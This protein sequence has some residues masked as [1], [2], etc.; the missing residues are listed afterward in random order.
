MKY[1]VAN[2]KLNGNTQFFK[3]YFRELKKYV[4]K[5]SQM[6]FAVPNCYLHLSKVLPNFAIG[7]QNI[8]HK[9]SGACTGEISAE[10]A[11]DLGAQFCLVGHSECRKRGETDNQIEQKLKLSRQ[12]G[13]TSILCIGETID[14]KSAFRQVLKRQLEVLKNVD[15]DNIIIAYEPV[16]AIGTNKTA[17]TRDIKTVHSFIKKYLMEKYEKAVPVLYGGSVNANNS[18]EILKLDVVD[19]VL[20]GGASLNALNFSNIY[21][22]QF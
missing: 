2:F 5:P 13:L 19:G 3:S 8:C 16:W 6:W 15:I 12:N 20:V 4:K 14:E 11:K 17:T 7:A 1:I 18:R 10:M 22:S 21:K 9:S